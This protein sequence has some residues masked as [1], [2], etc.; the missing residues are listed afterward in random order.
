MSVKSVIV[1]VVE[2][3]TDVLV[4]PGAGL[5]AV[6][7]LVSAGGGEGAVHAGELI[8]PAKAVAPIARVNRP[9]AQNCLSCF[10]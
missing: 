10:I 4:S 9:A 3:I 6:G 2:A 8:S 1:S 5:V 7:E